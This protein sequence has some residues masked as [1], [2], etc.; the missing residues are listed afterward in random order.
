MSGAKSPIAAV[1]SI[2]RVL[3]F[4]S[5]LPG[6]SVELY[7]FGL[8]ATLQEMDAKTPL[9][10]YLAEKIFDSLWWIRRYEDQKRATLVREM[11]DL[12]ERTPQGHYISAS[13]ERVIES[14]LANNVKPEIKQLLKQRNFSMESLRQV[15]YAKRRETLL[16]LDE[17]IA[18]KAK[19]L[20]GWAWKCHFQ[21][22]KIP[23]HANGYT[24]RRYSFTSGPRYI[25]DANW[26]FSKKEQLRRVAAAL[27]YLEGRYEFC[28]SSPCAIQPN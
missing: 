1:D 26:Q 19:T 13:K 14:L 16:R 20:S 9:Q 11:A 6:E 4:D 27:E 21:N 28:R 17:M 3:G 10:I 12:L 7:Q 25:F 24:C 8:T 22:A 5:V 23:Q 2:S 15:A 18:L